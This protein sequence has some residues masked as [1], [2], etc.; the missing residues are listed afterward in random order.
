MEFSIK[1]F[2]VFKVTVPIIVLCILI[3][4]LLIKIYMYLIFLSVFNI[5]LCI[6]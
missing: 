3:I 2:L 6:K 1:K 5:L 4:K